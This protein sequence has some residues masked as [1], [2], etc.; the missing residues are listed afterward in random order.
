MA[1]VTTKEVWETTRE[2]EMKPSVEDVQEELEQELQRF[3]E[4]RTIAEDACRTDE[5]RQSYRITHCD[6]W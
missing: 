6:C 4:F 2:Q 1:T 5:Q 3:E